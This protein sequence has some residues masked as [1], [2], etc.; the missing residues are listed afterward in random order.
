MVEQTATLLERIRNF[1]MP[2]GPVECGGTWLKQRGEAHG[3]RQ[4][5]AAI[6]GRAAVID[7]FEQ[8][9]GALAARVFGFLPVVRSPGP[10][11]DPGEAL[12]GLAEL[13][14]RPFAF[15]QGPP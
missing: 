1:A 4:A 13:P 2:E 5:M 9:R 6:R 14:W 12:R 7:S 3:R 8:G 11:T 10:D 15:R